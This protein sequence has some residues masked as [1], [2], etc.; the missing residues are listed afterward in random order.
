MT[1]R[2]TRTILVAGLAVL[3][4]LSLASAGAVAS[5]QSTYRAQQ[6]NA[7]YTVEVSFP[8]DFRVGT[9]QTIGVTVT[10]NGDTELFNP[11][12]EI[13]L[14][15][16]L[17]LS[18]GA[19]STAYVVTEDGTREHRG[20][21]LN[22]STFTSGEAV[23][24]Q[25][26][27]VPAG[28]QRTYYINFTATSAGT[29]ALTAEVRPLYNTD[30]AVRDQSSGYAAGYGSLAVTVVDDSGNTVS[31]ASVTYDG[32]TNQSAT[33]RTSV[34]E[35][36]YNVS[37]DASTDVPLPTITQ[38]VSVGQT[39]AM[40]FVAHDSATDPRVTGYAGQADV[41]S[42]SRVTQS[43]TATQRKRL[44]MSFLLLSDGGTTYLALRDPGSVTPYQ[45]HQAAAASG[46]LTTTAEQAVNQY[47]VDSAGDTK[48]NITYTGYKLGDVDGDDTVSSGDASTV[49]H[50]IAAGASTNQYG[51][52]NGDGN[53][54]AVDAM[55]IAQY[56]QGNR[57]ADYGEVTA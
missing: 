36:T 1:K 41:I 40:T 52:V 55:Y 16:S 34:V 28:A 2:T 45:H 44:N 17:S 32:T 51:D 22:Q 14:S 10:N 46:Q 9:N 42:V 13:P 56:N 30:L 35:G 39:T 48:V 47:K 37:A 50:S 19:T 20:A 21:E 43:P 24:I 33:V 6:T 31:G 12:V 18:K 23:F 15:T 38:S 27:T 57:T 5:Q 49:A 26:E 54:T 4:T 7:P 29:K 53:V 8:S 11:I 3:V 25:G